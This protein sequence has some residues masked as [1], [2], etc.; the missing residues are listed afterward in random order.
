[1]THKSLVSSNLNT[2]QPSR[3]TLKNRKAKYERFNAEQPVTQQV[4]SV[5]SM[6][7]P[8]EWNSLETWRNIA[9]VS[10]LYIIT[11]NLDAINPDFYISSQTSLTRQ[12]VFDT[13]SSAHPLTT[14]NSASSLIQLSFGMHYHLIVYLLLLWI[15]LIR[16]ITKLPNSEQSQ[17]QTH[18]N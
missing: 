4:D 13:S 17:I 3:H 16:V 6:L 15:S 18:Y 11:H 1:M 14:S 5:T 8:L 9:K 12:S 7:D 10:M 2:T